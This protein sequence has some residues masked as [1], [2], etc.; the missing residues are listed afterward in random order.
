MELA[1]KTIIITGA[2]SG[3]GASAAALFASEGAEVVLGARR[4]V[5]L[6]A[7]VDGIIASG[8]R[9]TCLAGDV[10]DQAYCEALVEHAVQA[11]GKLDGAFNNAGIV[12]E[13][14]SVPEMSIENWNDVVASNLTS[15][16]LGAK[17]QIPALRRQGRGAILFTSSFVGVSN[18]G[19]P[20]MAAYAATKA[21]LIGLMQ[22]LASDHAAEGIRI[23][24]LLPGGTVTPAGGEGNPDVLDFI[25]GLHPMKRM[26]TPG[27]IAQAA[28]F[29]L[30]DRSS[31]MTGSPTIADGGMSVRL[32]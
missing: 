5:E 13:M 21:G 27:E 18:G 1:D 7:V 4:S 22:S 30:S 31:F 24:A 17:A 3:I 32:I 2:S 29:L 9:A 8:G 23:N 19:L 12:G 11:F 10:R 15:A 26:A 25:S 28:L 6:E 14:V 16:F 20:G